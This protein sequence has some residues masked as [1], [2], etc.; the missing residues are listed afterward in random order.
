MLLITT[1]LLGAALLLWLLF[2]DPARD[3]AVAQLAAVGVA[4]ELPAASRPI[5]VVDGAGG[6][7]EGT[8]AVGEDRLRVRV[9]P[10][11]DAEAGAELA[12]QER[13]LLA[14][15]FVEHQ[16]PYP[17]ALSNTLRCPDALRPQEVEPRG[18]AL[19][20]VSLYANDRF[21]FGGCAE[22]LLRYRATAGAFYD[23]GLRELVRVE[24]FEPKEA[25]GRGPEVLRSFRWVG[26]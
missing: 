5:R 13:A 22:D 20:L 19:F 18:E 15:L 8:W 23:A 21:A 11:L 6:L 10:G 4:L 17:G 7:V 14:S 1:A 16:A 26:P 24:Y 12:R 2:G 9:S 3:P 25:A